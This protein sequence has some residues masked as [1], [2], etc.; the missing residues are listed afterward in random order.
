MQDNSLVVVYQLAAMYSLIACA[1]TIE[2]LR[3][4]CVRFQLDQLVL[5]KIGVAKTL[6]S[7]RSSSD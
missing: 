2:V 4:I 5:L 3:I 1:S 6:R 7:D